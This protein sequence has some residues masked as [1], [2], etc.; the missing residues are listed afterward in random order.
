MT[1]AD[2]EP[3]HFY[4]FLDK[5]RILDEIPWDENLID[6]SIKWVC[7]ELEHEEIDYCWLDFS[8]NK[9]MRLGWHKT[10]AVRF[11]YDRFEDYRPGKVGLILSL[12]Y[13]SMQ[14]SQRQYAKL[15][16]DA[17][18]AD[19]LFGLDLVGDEEQFDYKFYKPIFKD[20]KAAGKMLR[21]HV[22]ESQSP[23]NILVSIEQLQVTN[24]AHGLKVFAIPGLS[25]LARDQG[26]TFDLALTSNYLTGVW[27]DERS[28]PITHML[29]QGLKTTIGSDDPVQ[30]CTTLQREYALARKLGVSDE[31]CRKMATTAYENTKLF[32][33]TVS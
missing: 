5:F 28:H 22:G 25:T 13:E 17:A 9:Y 8:I 3:R 2:N 18:M 1:F 16:D 21:A 33:R 23:E 26:I 4:R 27:S 7:T 11:I 32:T 14:A 31:D 6:L 24:I 19:M 12:K 10:Q 29:A 30:C 15:I 20:W